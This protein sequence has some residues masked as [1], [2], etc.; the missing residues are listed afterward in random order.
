MHWPPR[1]P[2]NNGQQGV[3]TVPTRTHRFVRARRR[4]SGDDRFCLLSR[5][6]AAFI[7][8]RRPSS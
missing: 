1:V 5:L 4:S 8:D 6:M 7:S 3:T 2:E